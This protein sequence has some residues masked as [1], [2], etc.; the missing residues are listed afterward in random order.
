MTHTLPFSRFKGY[1]NDYHPSMMVYVNLYCLNE[2]Y[3]NKLRTLLV[4][5]KQIKNQFIKEGIPFDSQTITDPEFK[6][7]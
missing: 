6:E 5:G 7:L 4:K 2:L 1:L 3:R